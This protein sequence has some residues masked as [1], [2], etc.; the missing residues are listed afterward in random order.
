M[1]LYEYIH[2]YDISQADLALKCGLSQASLSRYA[3]GKAIPDVINGYRIEIATGGLVS[4]ADWINM[5]KFVLK[6]RGTYHKTTKAALARIAEQEKA[7]ERRKK[8]DRDV[9]LRD[10]KYAAQGI[11]TVTRNG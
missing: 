2:D 10:A 4:C 8:E 3:Q 6:R 7:D 9:Y 5:P 1:Q 11:L